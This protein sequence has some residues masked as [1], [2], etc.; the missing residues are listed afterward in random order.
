MFL[1]KLEVLYLMTRMYWLICIASL[2]SCKISQVSI[3]ISKRISRGAPRFLSRSPG[4]P[5]GVLWEPV[6]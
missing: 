3:L 1:S 6:C 2:D 4:A 5:Y